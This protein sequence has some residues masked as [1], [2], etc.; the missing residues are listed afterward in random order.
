M[1]LCKLFLLLVDLNQKCHLRADRTD[2]RDKDDDLRHTLALD[3][4]ETEIADGR[5]ISVEKSSHR[6]CCC[7][8][9]GVALVKVGNDGLVGVFL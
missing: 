3:V 2:N 7:A 5:G 1:F 4:I 8:T 9:R 6:E